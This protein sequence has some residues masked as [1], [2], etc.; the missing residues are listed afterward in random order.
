[1][2]AP[3][4]HINELTYRIEG[5]AVF[6]H[7]SV[8]IPAG[9]KVGVV[10][11]NGSGKTTL[12]RL[13]AGEL[14]PDDGAINLP[15]GTRI[16]RVA[17]EAP[18]TQQSLIDFVLSHDAERAILLQESEST[19]DPARIA[20]I[21]ER[22]AQIDAHAA[23]SRA[24]RILAGL[25]FDETAQ[26]RPCLEYS[27]GWRMRVALAAMLF[28]EP[29]L[30]LLDE[31]SNY[32]DLEGTL[33]LEDHL[34]HYPHALLLVSHDRELLNRSV[35]SILHLAHGKLTL[36]AGAYDQFTETRREKLRHD[37]KL[38]KKQEAERRRI[39]AF[40]ERF[41]AKASKA[42][43]AQSRLKA[44][45]RSQPIALEA[46]ERVAPFIF[47]NPAKEHASPL[48]GLEDAAAGYVSGSPVLHNLNLRL[49][50]DDRV[51]LLGANGNGKS[52]LAKLVA[53]HLLPM[54]GRRHAPKDL[55]VGYFGQHQLE[56]LSSGMSPYEH[57]RELMP[58]VTEAQRRARLGALGFGVNT[59]DTPAQNLSGGERARLLFL[60]A[61][62]HG[63]D[64]LILD[65]PTNHL[66]VEAREALVCALAEYR[67][68]V[69]LISHDRHLMDACVDRLW[70]V[71]DATVGTYNGDLDSYRAECLAERSADADRPRTRAGAEASKVRAQDTRRLAAEIRA[72]LSPLKERVLKAEIDIEHIGRRI[73]EIEAALA[74]GTL[75][76]ND[77]ARARA[78]MRERGEL[79]RAR[80]AAEES[81][82]VASE[83]YE[84]ARA[85]AQR[86]A[87]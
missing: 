67:G 45:A 65:E 59:A 38:K 66:D 2:A 56:D 85:Q 24:A 49:D 14:T 44:L 34:R 30:L 82:M 70:I 13:I 73:A 5:R 80:A 87:P 63:P 48:I 35:A 76:S 51:G 68:A 18:A 12:L 69:V 23:P 27:G 47:A 3:M 37:L 62:F 77:I 36:Y 71:R 11:R 74:D 43:Q 53:G 55:L 78:L 16:G 8:G 31:P 52:T 6:D 39:E 40:V 64:L 41:R 20:D 54:Q 75:Y 79:L 29:D 83:A 50:T 81:W 42:R 21:H 10:G 61:T 33:W 58:G 9:H 86:D 28:V 60:L 17:Q 15:R 46:E 7:A 1:M 22:L 25:G 57:M 72:A 32:L 26:Q 19:K 4:L 84:A